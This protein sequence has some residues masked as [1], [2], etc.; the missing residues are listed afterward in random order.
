MRARG[1]VIVSGVAS[2]LVLSAVAVSEATASRN[3]AATPEAATPP[4]KSLTVTGGDVTDLVPNGIAK[5]LQVLVANPKQNTGSVRITSV[6]ARLISAKL[7]SGADATACK[8]GIDQV[9]TARADFAVLVDSYL[10][11]AGTG[12]VLERNDTARAVPLS[13]VMPRSMQ[14]QDAC[15]GVRINLSYTATAAGK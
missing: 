11:A 8:I 14:S 9:G 3:G 10:P 13:I 12:I 4:P 5:D 1:L 6:K 15:K 7:P 2:A